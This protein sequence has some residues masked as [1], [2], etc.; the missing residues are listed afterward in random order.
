MEQ[1]I[2][3][4]VCGAKMK[5]ITRTHLAKHQMTTDQ[6]KVTFP[7]SPIVSASLAHE[8]GKASRN[9]SD[10]RKAEVSR[11]LSKANKGRP[12]TAEHRQKISESR[13][14]VSWGNHTPEHRERMRE[15]SRINM[16]ERRANGWAPRPFT[17]E[18]RAVIGNKVRDARKRKKWS[19]HGNR[20]KTLNLTPEQRANRS[21]KRVALIQ[22]DGGAFTN[23]GIEIKMQM[24]LAECDLDFV[25]QFAIHDKGSWLY[26]FFVPPLNLL[27][28]VDGEYFHSMSLKQVNRD[29]LKEQV[30]RRHGYDFVRISDKS[31]TPKIILRDPAT[32][33]EWCEKIYKKREDDIQKRS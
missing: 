23:T 1:K 14:G 30:A 25:H 17:D 22:R 31:W 8:L 10:E 19:G 20:G 4:R 27:I 2:E 13:A 11:Q 12:K 29:R 24:F 32:F 6:Y 21:R 28:E 5:R 3:C 15:I 26:D 16:I 18:E 33:T 9:M 7:N